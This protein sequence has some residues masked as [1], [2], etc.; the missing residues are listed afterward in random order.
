MTRYLGLHNP[1]NMTGPEWVRPSRESGVVLFH[2]QR[3]QSQK[4]L[5]F[6]YY[7]NSTV[8]ANAGSGPSVAVFAAYAVLMQA[9]V[10]RCTG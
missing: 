6:S 5:R 9:V 7:F 3:G 8:D 1:L 10:L 4:N 2:L